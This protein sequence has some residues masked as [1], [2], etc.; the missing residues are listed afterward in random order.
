M[1]QINQHEGQHPLTIREYDD[2]LAADFGDISREWIN[3]MFHLEAVD[4]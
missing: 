1:E 3:A 4:V 2:T